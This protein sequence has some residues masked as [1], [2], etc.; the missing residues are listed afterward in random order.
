MNIMKDE[1]VQSHRDP[2]HSIGAEFFEAEENIFRLYCSV[3][4]S[5]TKACFVDPDAAPDAMAAEVAARAFGPLLQP[6]RH[7]LSSHF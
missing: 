1:A 4:P 6:P 5:V 7:E 3:V 2:C